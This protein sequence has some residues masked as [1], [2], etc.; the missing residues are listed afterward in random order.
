MTAARRTTGNGA[1]V[2]V[3]VLL[4]GAN[5]AVALGAWFAPRFHLAIT[6]SATVADIGYAYVAPLPHSRGLYLLPTDDTSGPWSTA[7]VLE[8]EK[9]LGPAH[10][11]LT[12]IRQLGGGRFSH[13]GSSLYF[14]SSDLTDP[15]SNG[16]T[17]SFSSPTQLN[18]A[19]LWGLAALNLVALFFLRL[20]LKRRFADESGLA[21]ATGPGGPGPAAAWMF[22]AV[23]TTTAAFAVAGAGN[24]EYKTNDDVNMRMIAEGVIGTGEQSQFLLFQ[25]VLVG[26][27]L[28]A[29]YAAAPGWPW[30]DMLLAGTAV[31]G[32][33]LCQTAVLRLCRSRS[34]VAFGALASFVLFT[35][36]FRQ[37]QFT[38]SAML[39][40]GGAL[41]VLSS[42]VY[43]PPSPG[44]RR[45]ASAII[46]LSFLLGCL[47]RL[48]GAFLILATILPIPLLVGWRQLG[49]NT[50]LPFGAVALGTIV[51][52]L[53]QGFDR[54]YYARSPGWETIRHEF[55]VRQRATEYAQLDLSQPDAF[56]D[57]LAA[58]EW[59]SNDYELLSGWLF[60]D[61]NLFSAERLRRFAE[62]A[63]RK[64][65]M[66][67]ALTVHRQLRQGSGIFWLLPA[68][69][70]GVLLVRPS[71]RALA[72]VLL[73]SGMLVGVLA[74][75]AVLF[76]AWFL[77]IIWPLYTVVFFAAAAAAWTGRAP[78]P[79]RTKYVRLE[80][81]ILSAA[82][83]L[84][85]GLAAAW[86]VG[87][88]LSNGA[89]SEML[90]GQLA[91]DL[92]AWPAG[93]GSTVV[94]WGNNFPFEI[95]A[96]PFRPLPATPWSFLHTNSTS[97]TPHA[98]PIYAR[99]GTADIAWAMCHVPQVYRVEDP[100]LGYAADHERALETYM[101]EHYREVVDTVQVFE[102]DRLSLYTCRQR[103]AEPQ[104]AGTATPPT[105]PPRSR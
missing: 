58:A 104:R 18:P 60:A 102:G 57:A 22:A 12:E 9:P 7:Q 3:A 87:S 85:A 96:R 59:T 21:P 15:R 10:T 1:W 65:V 29:L 53:G 80:R 48:E 40:A 4:V 76:K 83:V 39:L 44:R 35:P 71:A 92:A 19:F 37:L 20:F 72:A 42:V 6:P 27:V 70:L 69:C 89:A 91:R 28:R 49:R 32:A 45:A 90:R 8:G 97:A 34:E 17:Y 5:A 30:Y 16:R 105:S 75:L 86:Q 98:D 36:L 33:L 103:T 62:L 46:F 11:L 88:V 84:G 43:R 66:Q 68:L 95:W 13:W 54:S 82:A 100:G 56:R 47:I 52:L 25:N 14:S 31:A 81:R 99:W 23:L 51:A 55:V 61:R 26:L 38:A 41:L 24:L 64:P 2:A 77:H 78:G 93:T 73:S 79:A 94:V 67:R 50:L 101:Q 74:S 63:P